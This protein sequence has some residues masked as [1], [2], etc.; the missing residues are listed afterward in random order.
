MTNYQDEQQNRQNLLQR[1]RR[2][3]IV[4]LAYNGTEVI[5]T[6]IA[7]F[8]AGSSALIAFGLDSFIEVIAASML[9]WRLYGEE[10]GASDEKTEHR[11]RITLYVVGGTFFLLSVFI[12]SD[13]IS[14]LVNEQRPETS[15]IGMVILGVSLIV[16]PFLFWG[17]Y[18]TGKQLDSQALIA[19]S[20]ET[21]VCLYQTIVVLLGLILNSTLSFWWA[22]PVAALLI[23]P[24]VLWQG[25]DAI[26][27]ARS[28][29]DM[30]G[31]V[32][33]DSTA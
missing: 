32:S 27:E 30:D 31:K 5:V 6:L 20:K 13:A 7:G 10:Q 25:W 14:K 22:D 29:G 18:H 24:Y 16:N 21:L 3:E 15:I 4:N 11:R 33:Q 26:H 1:G 17:K 12:L 28:G 19:D 8:L 2:I 23:V 9:I